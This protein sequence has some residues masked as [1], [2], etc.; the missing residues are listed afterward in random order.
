MLT[1]LKR[2]DTHLLYDQTEN[3]VD[4]ISRY[5]EADYYTYY[6]GVSIKLDPIKAQK[7]REKRGKGKGKLI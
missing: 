3:V 1:R 5:I 6:L 7:R 4:Q 2:P